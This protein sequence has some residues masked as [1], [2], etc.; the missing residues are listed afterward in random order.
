MLSQGYDIRVFI[1]DEMWE[2]EPRS[3][4]IAISP[5]CEIQV[6]ILRS[7]QTEDLSRQLSSSDC[8][9]QVILLSGL[10]DSV[11]QGQVIAM[12]RNFTDTVFVDIPR[13]QLPF[14]DWMGSLTV[15]EWRSEWS[16]FIW[17]N[18]SLQ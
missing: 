6:T 10:E 7:V 8:I 5:G 16:H 17:R 13:T 12:K 2:D 1:A 18:A 3:K 4:Q 11:T 14:C 15:E 9:P